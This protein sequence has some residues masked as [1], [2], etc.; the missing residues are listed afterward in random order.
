MNKNFSGHTGGEAGLVAKLTGRVGEP[1]K[2]NIRVRAG[3]GAN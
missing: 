3:Q 1:E 2:M